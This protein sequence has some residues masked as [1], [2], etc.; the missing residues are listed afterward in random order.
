VR[1][2]SYCPVCGAG[3]D[4]SA[5]GAEGEYLCARCGFSFWQNSKPAVS[6]LIVRTIDGEPQVLLTQRGIEPFRGMWDLPG[7]FLRNGEH[8]EAGLVRELR[9]ELGVET[10]RPR[11]VGSDIDEY[12]RDDIAEEA[13]FVLDLSFR[14]EIPPGAVLTP[15]DDV[16]AFRWFSLERLP[17][18]LAFAANRRALGAL[19]SALAAEVRG[20]GASR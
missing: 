8:P 15:A 2:Y 18:D 12:V 13:R 17:D 4:H 20:T 19:Q 7:G 5:S 9:E 6:A 3:Y 10:L 16:V 1:R 14:C 11:L